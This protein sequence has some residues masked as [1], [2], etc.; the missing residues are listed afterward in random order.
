[1]RKLRGSTWTA[2]AVGVAYGVTAQCVIRLDMF[3]S[4]FGVMSLGYIF[5]LPFVLGFVT[6]YPLFHQGIWK[7]LGASLATNALCLAI[8]FAVGWEGTIC[9]I[10]RKSVV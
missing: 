5:L 3:N 2:I 8:A 9:L 10:D 4:L 6:A 7:S 1:M